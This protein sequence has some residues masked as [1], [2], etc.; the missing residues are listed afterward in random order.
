MTTSRAANPWYREPWPWLLMSGPALVIVAG[1]ATTVLAVTTS[2]G[3]VADDYYRQGLAINRTLARDAAAAALHVSAEVRFNE[4]RTHARVRVA[5]DAVPEAVRMTLVHPTRA[6]ADQA[7]AMRRISPGL[8]EGRMQ[9]P[10]A[11]TWRVRIEDAPG[12]WRLTGTWRTRDATASLAA[13]H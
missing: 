1:I 6:G 3:V 10:P 2:D 8:Y 13:A 4:E 9:A 12:T 11:G 5:A 7:V